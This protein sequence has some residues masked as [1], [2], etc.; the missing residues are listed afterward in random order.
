MSHLRR[1]AAIQ[2]QLG[3]RPAQLGALLTMAQLLIERGNPRAARLQLLQAEALMNAHTHPEDFVRSW[4][5]RLD[6]SLKRLEG[7]REGLA[8]TLAAA[9]AS[10]L[11]AGQPTLALEAQLELMALAFEESRLMDALQLIQETM[12]TVQRVEEVQLRSRFYRLSAQI[13]RAM[14]ACQLGALALSPSAEQSQ[15]MSTRSEEAESAMTHRSQGE[16]SPHFDWLQN[17][18][19]VVQAAHDESAL[20]AA[21]A[22]LLGDRFGGRGMV[23]LFDLKGVRRLQSAGVEPLQADELSESV[24]EQVRNSRQT[25][26]Y[27]DILQHDRMRSLRSLREGQVR[28]VVCVPLPAAGARGGV[29]YVDHQEPGYLT[30]PEVVHEIERIA[31]LTA[32]LLR[33]TSQPAAA[34]DDSDDLGLIGRSEPMCVLRRE[35]RRLAA[36]S[37]PRLRV[38]ITGE[39]GTGKSCVAQIL[40]R[41]GRRQAGPFESINCGAIP[42]SLVEAELFGVER[43]VATAVDARA[44]CLERSAGGVLLLDELGDLPLEQ[45]QKFLLVLTEHSF[46]RLGGLRPRPFDAWLIGATSRDLRDM[47]EEKRFRGDLLSRLWSN[48]LELPSLRTRGAQDITLLLQHHLK[49]C[50]ETAHGATPPSLLPASASLSASEPLLSEFF[51]RRALQ[52]LLHE[53]HWPWNV[54]ELEALFENEEMVSLI[55][56]GGAQKVDR[57]ALER[58]LWEADSLTMAGRFRHGRH[59]YAA[60]PTDATLKELQHWFEE[61]KACH[62][63]QVLEECQGNV[64]KAA[65]RLGCDRGTLYAYLRPHPGRR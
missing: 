52:F 2:S 24:L 42:A 49:R 29:M 45:Q 3:N 6:A 16:P 56:T 11:A 22:Q 44:G 4:F 1:A 27:P 34:E 58:V 41:M 17:L 26:T 36:S 13:N 51:T 25:L 53:Y 43:G 54:R 59:G 39:V 30:R 14:E 62:F 61:L 23:L 8:P 15:G 20:A 48:R 35:L 33:G 12:P 47:V 31:A 63:K 57:P 38:L 32:H 9:T 18:E 19:R 60:P 40:H 65:R 28:S 21:L 10:L 5:A 64:A 55:L 50:R 46:K 37:N 7:S